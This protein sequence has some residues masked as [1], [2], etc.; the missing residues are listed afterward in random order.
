MLIASESHRRRPRRSDGSS[1]PPTAKRSPI[2]AAFAQLIPNVFL[3]ET[4]KS[5]TE[6]LS[7][8]HRVI[9]VPFGLPSDLGAISKMQEE[10]VAEA[11]KEEQKEDGRGKEEETSR[12]ALEASQFFSGIY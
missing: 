3:A 10:A 6:R 7:R 8:L 12:R 4:L 1:F 11:V 9:V 5:R 2:A